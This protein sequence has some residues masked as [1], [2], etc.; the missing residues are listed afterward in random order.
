MLRQHSVID[1]HT[2]FNFGHEIIVITTGSACHSHLR[3]RRCGAAPSF[4]VLSSRCHAA[5]TRTECARRW[6]CAAVHSQ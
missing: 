6:R 1:V 3:R 4:N 5:P 2:Y